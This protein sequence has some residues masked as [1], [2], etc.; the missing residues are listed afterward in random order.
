MVP[1]DRGAQDS[2]EKLTAK[3]VLKLAG[4]GLKMLLKKVEGCLDGTPAKAP[5]VA[6]NALI[7]ITNV[8]RQINVLDPY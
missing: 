5:V 7:D 1:A 3:D 6:L 8:C 2:D 4:S